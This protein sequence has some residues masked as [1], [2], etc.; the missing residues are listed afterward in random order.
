MPIPV[1]TVPI[2]GPIIDTTGALLTASPA[3]RDAGVISFRGG[4]LRR[5]NAAGDGWLDIPGH[6]IS[7]TEPTETFEGLLWYDTTT[8]LL[9]Q[10]NGAAFV[11]LGG[12][13]TITAGTTVPSGGADG[14]A[15]IQVD[16]SDVVQS[17]WR[18]VSGTWT[19]YTLPAGGSGTVTTSAPVSGDGSASDPVTIANQ[20]IG[21]TKL[22]SSVAGT[23]QAAGR[24]L[25]ADGA[26]DM[27]WADKGGGSG[28][29]SGDAL[30]SIDFP[31]PDSTNVYDVI[32]HLGVLYRNLPTL[33][34][35]TVTWTASGDGDDVS[36]L[37][38]EQPGTYRFRG[39]QATSGVSSPLS[40]DVVF[41]PGWWIPPQRGD[42]VEPSR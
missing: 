18:N 33:I 12:G 25:E 38:G 24:I 2:G 5:V 26:G 35:G 10:Y 7:A 42:T 20:A 27:R 21:H 4:R 6:V 30:T 22:G 32:D 37:W 19:E 16:G 8:N 31:T 23:D 11:T 34:T 9:K 41:A 40:G 3:L 28:G 39:I 14:D 29:G 15:Y 13:T 1:G 36:D 17:L